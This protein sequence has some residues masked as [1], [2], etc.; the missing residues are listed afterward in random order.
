MNKVAERLNEML[1]ESIFS[2]FLSEYGQRLYFPQEIIAQKR[3]AKQKATQYNATLDRATD[4][5]EPM[6]FD[7]IKEQFDACL[8]AKSIFTPVQAGGKPQLQK[9]WGKKMLLKNPSLE[10]AN[11]STPLLTGGKT[12]A[13]NIIASLFI[14]E[15]DT[16]LLPNLSEENYHIII[17]ERKARSHHYPLFSH[18]HFNTQGIE[19]AINLSKQ[20][21]IILILNFPNNPAGYSPTK[22]EAEEIQKS[23]ISQAQKGKKILVITDDTSFGLFYE[24]NV[25]QES[26][27][28][29]LCQADKNILCVKIDSITEEEMAWGFCLACIT[30]GSLGV[31]EEIYGAIEQ[32]VMG[33]IQ[34]TGSYC[35]TPDQNIILK[36]M[37]SNE[38]A[39]QKKINMI[40]L[41]LRYKQLKEALAR[42]KDDD[43]LVPL[44]CNSG[45]YMTL[46]TP[47]DANQLRVYLLEQYQIGVLAIEEHLLCITFAAIE[48]ED[49]GPLIDCI[50]KAAHEIFE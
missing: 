50:Y 29:P 27:F 42:H 30:F 46:S 7:A 26:L 3:E 23:I 6:Y 16:V 35:S 19:D 12:S 31:T 47:H 13:L 15:G 36:A 18:N 32:K 24:E 28:A 1:K 5:E 17:R 49:I 37:K 20:N 2:A 10:K 40:T 39:V 44:P 22:K 25:W 9:L 33:A 21:K 11:I 8:P 48:K 38:Y 34:A 4:K 43:I 14:D 45:Y 41:A